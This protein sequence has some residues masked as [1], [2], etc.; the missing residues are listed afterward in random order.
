MLRKI[1]AFAFAKIKEKLNS[2]SA[3]LNEKLLLAKNYESPDI[4]SI[5][6]G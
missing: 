6:E 2:Y 4:I 1:L 3:T 5:Y